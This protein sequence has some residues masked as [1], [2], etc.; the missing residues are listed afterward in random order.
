M[1]IGMILV[2][3]DAEI[4]R[5]KTKAEELGERAYVI[6]EIKKGESRVVYV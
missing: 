3:P 6:G 1:G 2:A 5:I 4:E